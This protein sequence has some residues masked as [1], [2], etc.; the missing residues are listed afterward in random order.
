MVQENESRSPSGPSLPR[1]I[2]ALNPEDLAFIK[3]FVLASGSLKAVAEEY[4]VSYPTIRARIDRLIQKVRI[5]DDDAGQDAFERE[6][7]LLV[8]DDAISSGAARRILEAHRAAMTI[9]QD[10]RGR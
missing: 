10:R 7:R 9:Q 3:R 5:A 6:L 1:W 2:A 4:G 8:A